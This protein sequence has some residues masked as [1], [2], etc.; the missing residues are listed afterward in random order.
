MSFL[1]VLITM[2][3]HISN[4]QKLVASTELLKQKVDGEYVL[5]NLENQ[6]YYA[7]DLV[8]SRIWDVL[9]EGEST[10]ASVELLLEE[11]EVERERLEPD[12]EALIGD[13][14]SSGLAKLVSV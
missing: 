2:G 11:Y 9:L 3:K 4:D 6:N 7:L 8:G 5:V 12:I 1:I 10:Q 14:T 13:L